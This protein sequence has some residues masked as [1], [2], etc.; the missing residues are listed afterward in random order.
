MLGDQI[1][2]DLVNAKGHCGI[3]PN[4]VREFGSHFGLASR[5]LCQ[6]FQLLAPT[7]SQARIEFN[8]KYTPSFNRPPYHRLPRP[9]FSGH[10]AFVALAT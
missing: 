3:I 8:P 5:D 1:L 4:D 6:S 10:P 2:S 9:F 7:V